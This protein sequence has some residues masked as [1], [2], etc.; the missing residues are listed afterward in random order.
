[1]LLVSRFVRWTLILVAAAVIAVRCYAADQPIATHHQA[2]TF[3]CLGESNCSANV[4]R[5]STAVPGGPIFLNSL[6][7][8]VS[9]QADSQK[10]VGK[11]GAWRRFEWR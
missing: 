11:S 1:M 8:G 2:F 5:D 3:A 10:W 6:A 4:N 7:T 9:P